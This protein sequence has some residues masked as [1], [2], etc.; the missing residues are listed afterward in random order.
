VESVNGALAA[1]V[2]LAGF[3]PFKI[4]S[5]R[6]ADKSKFA[7]SVSMVGIFLDES[8]ISAVLK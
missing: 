6:N 8:S 7:E 3:E 2:L 5:P 4:A 1:S